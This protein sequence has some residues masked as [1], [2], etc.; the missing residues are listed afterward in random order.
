MLNKSF[1]LGD[2]NNWLKTTEITEGHHKTPVENNKKFDVEEWDPITYLKPGESSITPEEM[3]H[4]K[5]EHF[6]SKQF[7]SKLTLMVDKIKKHQSKQ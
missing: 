4:R 5:K 1:K 7:L 2:A 3:D 6:A